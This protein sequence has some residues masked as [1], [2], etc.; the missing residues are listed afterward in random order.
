MSRPPSLEAFLAA[1]FRSGV[2]YLELRALPSGAQRFIQSDAWHT[3]RDFLRKH[4]VR[5][6]CFF[7]VAA[8]RVPG[9][10]GGLSNCGTLGALFVDIDFKTIREAEAR[11]ALERFGVPPSAVVAS[12]GGLHAYWMLTE[13]V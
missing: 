3:I 9:Q 10:G 8:R 4:I 12:G 6:H 11:Q 2:G 5:E 13:P 7:G 1:L